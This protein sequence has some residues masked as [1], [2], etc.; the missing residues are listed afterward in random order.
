MKHQVDKS[1]LTELQLIFLDLVEK[2]LDSLEGSDWEIKPH[3]RRKAY[4]IDVEVKPRRPGSV[5]VVACAEPGEIL[6]LVG[7]R[8]CLLDPK[9]EDE[10]ASQTARTA[11][12][13][14][15]AATCG[16]LKI[17]ARKASGKPYKWTWCLYED[18]KWKRIQGEFKL[19]FNWFGHRS[20]EEFIINQPEADR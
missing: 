9:I 14:L 10:P 5:A 16:R 4:F 8:E 13:I 1:R 17:V 12:A 3:G 7:D 11:V 20:T 6:I 2:W 18:G 15:D 19:L